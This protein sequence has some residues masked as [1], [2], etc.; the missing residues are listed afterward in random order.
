MAQ[1]RTRES[2]ILVKVL[3]RCM[4]VGDAPSPLERLFLETNR[5]FCCNQYAN[6]TIM[7]I[8]YHLK[9]GIAKLLAA[10][11]VDRRQF[12]TDAVALL[13]RIGVDEEEVTP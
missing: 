12:P 5:D 13:H 4:Y 6:E 3:A 7:K 9:G 8:K 10:I 1:G 11:K 2:A